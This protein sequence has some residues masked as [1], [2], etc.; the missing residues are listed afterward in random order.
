MTGP[1][2][3]ALFRNNPYLRQSGQTNV[4][5]LFRER[6][7][8][9]A[10]RIAVVDRDLRYTF[11][12]LN[13]RV[14][15]LANALTGLGVEAGDRIAMLASNRVEYIDAELAA[16]K[17]GA[18][19]CG[20]NWRLAEPELA[21][22]FNLVAPRVL[23]YEAQYVAEP[24]GLQCTI[25]HRVTLGDHYDSLLAKAATTEPGYQGD[26]EDGLVIIYTSGTTGLPKGAVISHRAMIARASVFQ[27]EVG[28]GRDD[29]FIAWAPFY[30]MASTD[31]SLA[32][33]LMGATVYI[34]NGYDGNAIIDIVE[35]ERIGWLVLIPGMIDQFLRDLKARPH[36]FKPLGVRCIGAMADLVPPHQLIE[37]TTLLNAPY[38]NSFGSTETGLPPAT[39]AQIPI[40]ERPHSL[41]KRIS[42]LCQV[43]LVDAE[44]NEVPVGAPGEMAVRG[45]TLFSG[46]WNAEEVNRKEFRNGWFHMGDLFV[47]HADGSVDFVDRSKYMI[48]SGG[49]NIYPAEIER[50]LL[51]NK[52]VTEAAVIRKLDERWGEIPVAYV[53]RSDTALTVE[54]LLEDC[55]RQLAGYKRPKEIHFIAFDDFPR[56]TAGKVQRHK[57]EEWLKA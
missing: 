40:G 1:H 12:I 20:I 10:D 17:L 44:D 33:L 32:T 28:L 3:D 36:P 34:V 54:E 22:C 38:V 53:A 25:A 30:H 2:R 55:R 51:A 15:R 16:A 56:S 39:G 8:N 52:S 42:G 50:V 45:P 49:E 18:I 48:K 19:L 7:R 11:A 46:Y 14:N 29:G 6:V 35:R 21:H 37:V 24:A 41:A 43:K 4:A 57:M 26:A 13:E 23:I 9:D 31:Q 47:R 5:D 27:S